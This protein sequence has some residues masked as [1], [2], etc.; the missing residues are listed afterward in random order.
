MIQRVKDRLGHDRRYAIDSTRIRNELGWSPRI[1]FVTGLTETVQW[2]RQNESW[3]RAIKT[4]EYLEYYKLQY[5][6]A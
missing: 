6:A 1:D 3:W 4:G 2:Y 5:G